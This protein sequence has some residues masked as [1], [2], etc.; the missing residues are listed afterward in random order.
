[1]KVLEYIN[2]YPV[3]IVE[4]VRSL[5]EKNK[6]RDYLKSKYPYKHAIS[7]E[8]ALYDFVLDYKKRYLKQSSPI[9]KVSYDSK[10]QLV[11]HALGTHTY[12]SRVQGGKLK[13]KQEIRIASLFKETPQALLDM[14]VVHELAHLKEK[15]HNKAFYKLCL[16]M[17]PDYYQLE[18]DTR[19]FLIEY[20]LNGSLY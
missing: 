20:E 16:H 17:L 10:L 4:Q 19:L 11:K 6:L 14:I 12:I 9:S 15:D 18:L 3:N 7:S 1:M 2:H 13:A 5:I 8:K